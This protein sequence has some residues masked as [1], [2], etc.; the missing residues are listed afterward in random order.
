[1]LM[2]GYV[3]GRRVGYALAGDLKEPARRAIA[4]VEAL[5][6]RPIA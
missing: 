6:G 4:H 2:A 3:P 5:E 1:M